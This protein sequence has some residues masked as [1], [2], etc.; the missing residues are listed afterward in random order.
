VK[1]GGQG[2]TAA[3]VRTLPCPNR[4]CCAAVGWWA[5]GSTPPL[6]GTSLACRQRVGRHKR[7]RC[8][9]LYSQPA[10]P[11]RL[12]R[13]RRGCALCRQGAI[14]ALRG[15][16]GKG[17]DPVPWSAVGCPRGQCAGR[18]PALTP[19]GLARPRVA[20][21]V[22]GGLQGT[23]SEGAHMRAPAARPQEKGEPTPARPDAR[24]RCLAALC[25]PHC[26]RCVCR[27]RSHAGVSVPRA[28]PFGPSPT[29]DHRAACG[30]GKGPPARAPP[31]VLSSP[32]I[33][34]IC[35]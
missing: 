33:I 6:S 17:A 11:P 2:L 1:G 15:G 34:N 10:T 18:V 24:E 21:G 4:G 28:W 22:A 7:G 30:R 25:W 35:G 23:E 29:A 13:R 32:S 14:T 27:S 8:W 9:A 5:L 20:A 16:R 26:L 3:V 19:D 31:P 12:L